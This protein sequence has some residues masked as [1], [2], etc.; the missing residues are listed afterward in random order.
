MMRVFGHHIAVPV[1]LLAGLEAG[2]L[3]VL[4]EGLTSLFDF[5][6]PGVQAILSPSPWPSRP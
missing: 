2:V 5:L 3:V 1:L 4:F 6:W